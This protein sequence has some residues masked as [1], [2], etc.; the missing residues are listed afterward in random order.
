[1]DDKVLSFWEPGAPVYK[2]R[3]EA[4]RYAFD[5]GFKTSV[6]MEPML[7]IANIDK[8]IKEVNQ[9]VN[10]DIWLGPMSHLKRISRY[11]HDSALKNIDELAAAQTTESLRPIYE[12]YKDDSKIR[13]KHTF[14]EAIGLA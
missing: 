9:F 12:R 2:E 7:D 8:V 3:K 13:F 4:L 1:M 6:S 5:Y 11:T 14:L 10:E